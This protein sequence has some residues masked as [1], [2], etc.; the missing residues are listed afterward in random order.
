M[1][2]GAPIREGVVPFYMDLKVT[3]SDLCKRLVDAFSSTDNISTYLNI[4]KI[5]IIDWEVTYACSP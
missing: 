4:I 5:A 3:H 2:S 1:Q